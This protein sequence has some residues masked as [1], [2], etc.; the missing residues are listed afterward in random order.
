MKSALFVRPGAPLAI[1]T[2][3]DPTPAP[4]QLVIRVGRCGICG[5]DLQM[6]D[7]ASPVHF[8]AG[9]ALGHEYAGE[10]V[11][12]GRDVT[13]FAIGDR[14]TAIP[15][16][17]C[18]TCPACRA[19]DPG[20]CAHSRYLMGGF[21][22]YTLADERYTARLPA[23]LSLSD[24]ALIEPLACGGQAARL[25]DIGPESRVLVLGAGPIG[26]T[27]IYWARRAGCRHIAVVAR[28]RRNAELA[29]TMGADLF[30]EQGPELER[31]VADA[32]GG[33]P[34]TVF[35][36]T[37][38]PGLIA[39]AIACVRPRGSIIVSGMCF[40]PETFVPGHALLKQVRLQFS[41]A[42]TMRDFQRGIDAMDAGAVEP[43]IMLAETIPLAALPATL[44]T[45]RH[46]HARGKIMVDPWAGN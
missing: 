3:P 43:R 42:Y 45:L 22:Q 24:G 15:M 11:A 18:G 19:E 23:S 36:C 13:R 44:E 1:E 25:G 29:H 17:G 10:V 33:L 4:D 14:V 7:A 16:S 40:A 8:A 35:E 38:S 39:Q 2:V 26:L 31:R 27:I 30:I 41:L 21:S 12:L 28:S 37:G 46:T 9:A 5:S 20:S 34:D 32:L 6:T